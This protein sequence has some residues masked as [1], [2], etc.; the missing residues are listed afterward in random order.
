MELLV[1]L[2]AMLLLGAAWISANVAVVVM[3]LAW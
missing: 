2:L 1:E 3:S